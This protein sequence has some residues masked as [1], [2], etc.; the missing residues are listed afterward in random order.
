MVPGYGFPGRRGKRR[1]AA[2][3]PAPSE[4]RRPRRGGIL[5]LAF[6]AI[7][8]ALVLAGLTPGAAK[9]QTTPFV[10]NVGF[11]STP[12]D[13]TWG[14]GEAIWVWVG[15]NQDMTVTGTPRLALT[16]GANTRQADFSH[17]HGTQPNFLYFV[18]R[19]QAS[20]TDTDGISIGAS[21]LSLNGG[22]IG[23]GAITRTS[24]LAPTP[25]ATSPPTRWT[26]P[27]PAPRRQ[28]G[29]LST[30]P[31]RAAPPTDR[32][33]RSRWVRFDKVVTVTG[34]PRLALTIG[35]NTAQA[36]YIG[37]DSTRTYLFFDYTVQPGD[38]DTDGVSIPAS[39]LTLNGGTIR[40]GS[41]NA[42]LGLG[43]NAL[44]DQSAHKVDGGP[45]RRV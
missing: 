32:T 37:Q 27:R 20:D 15:F 3:W 19:V 31:R 28:S 44:G 33:R 8:G 21:A 1:S 18:Y 42:N 38:I 29:W 23:R 45:C 43:A 41:A 25:S 36:D 40:T 4:P 22:A 39:A 5:L 11:D 10:T 16:I 7:A 13:N 12:P 34:T 6:A 30:A 17:V 26:A 14:L 35:T 24:T 9:A 2:L